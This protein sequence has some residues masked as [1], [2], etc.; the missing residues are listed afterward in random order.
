MWIG[1]RGLGAVRLEWTDDAPGQVASVLRED[2]G[3]PDGPMM[4]YRDAMDCLWWVFF[5][6]KII[7]PAFA[8]MQGAKIAAEH[9]YLS[10]KHDAY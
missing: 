9:V 5:R 10:E 6:G 4:I 3:N 1:H 8:N 2:I 7:Q